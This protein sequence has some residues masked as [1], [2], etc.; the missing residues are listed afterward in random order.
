MQARE[1]EEFQKAVME[2]RKEKAEGRGAAVIK[3]VGGGFNNQQEKIVRT[4]RNEGSEGKEGKDLGD[5][6]KKEGK[7]EESKDEEK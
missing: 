4:D 7:V 6:D 3:D 5:D 1:T 2:W